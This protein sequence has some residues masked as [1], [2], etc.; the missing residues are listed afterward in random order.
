M[1]EALNVT[2]SNSVNN[3]AVAAAG[4]NTGT[5]IDTAGA[6]VIEWIV[7]YKLDGG[8]NGSNATVEL[9]ESDDTNASNFATVTGGSST[10][11]A[12][13][14]VITDVRTVR[15]RYQR[16]KVTSNSTNTNNAL[17]LTVN[18]ALSEQRIVPKQAS[19]RVGTTG[20][21]VLVQ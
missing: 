18:A 9:Q 8:T 16:V 2:R 6:G 5:V 14:L 11:A 7:T 21:F 13:P 20:T 19:E 3:A 10:A 1:V 12:I 15:K 17:V 4:N